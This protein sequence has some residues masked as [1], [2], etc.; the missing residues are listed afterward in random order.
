MW[1]EGKLLLGERIMHD[2]DNCWQFPGGQLEYGEDVFDCAHREVLE[3][4]G[5]EIHQLAPITFTNTAF[6]LSQRHYIT[7]FVSA[8]YCGGRLQPGEPD[9]CRRWQWFSPDKLPTPLFTPI[10][11]LLK[12][13]PD[14]SALA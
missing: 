12:S 9:K 13:H 10:L 5:L 8:Q 1:R 3:E 6:I 2:A 4:A 11:Q 14:L 7:L